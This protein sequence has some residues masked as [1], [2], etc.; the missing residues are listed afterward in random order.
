MVLAFRV[1]RRPDLLRPRANRSDLLIGKS[2][3]FVHQSVGKWRHPFVPD[4]LANQTQV[5]GGFLGT[6]LSLP[7]LKV[8][9]APTHGDI[10][11]NHPR[12]RSEAAVPGPF[13]LAGMTVATR[14]FQDG[15]DVRGN[16]NMR[17]ERPGRDNGRIGALG[18][19][20]LGNKKNRYE[21]I[22]DSLQPDP[23]HREFPFVA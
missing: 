13:R 6:F 16:V 5:F 2:R 12:N 18:L 9:V 11:D 7:I 21:R 20:E 22:S 1:R 17:F 4:F 14:S 19:Y 3:V 23:I 10:V 8:D 15:Q